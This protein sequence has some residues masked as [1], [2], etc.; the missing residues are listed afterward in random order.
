[1]TKEIL[2]RRSDEWSP[3]LQKKSKKLQYQGGGGGGGGTTLTVRGCS[4]RK[5]KEL[6]EMRVKVEKSSLSQDV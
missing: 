4:R 6:E 5:L 3:N 1:M 2:N